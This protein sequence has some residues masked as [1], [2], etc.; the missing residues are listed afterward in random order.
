MKETSLFCLRSLLT[1]VAMETG[2]LPYEMLLRY[3]IICVGGG[4]DDEVFDIYDIMRGSFPTLETGACTLFIKA[5]S[6]TAR[7]RDAIGILEDVKKVNR[8]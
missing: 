4:H 1:F 8:V 2:T 3:L 5:F 6:R 7:W